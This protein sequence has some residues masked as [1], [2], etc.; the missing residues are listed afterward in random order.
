MTAPPRE[1]LDRPWALVLITGLLAMSIPWWRPGGDGPPSIWLGM[2]S[3]AL[4][5]LGCTFAASCLVA[6]AALRL[7]GDDR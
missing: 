1:P 2:P 7:W 4:V 3:W 5:S 6:F